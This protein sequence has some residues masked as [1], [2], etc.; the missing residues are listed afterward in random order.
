MVSRLPQPAPVLAGY[1]AVRPLGSGGFADVYLYE[2]GMPRREVA[3]KV[4]LAELCSVDVREMF[5]SE[6]TLMA[7]LST[8]PSALTVYEANISADGRPYLVMEYCPG[9]F[10][11]RFRTER[12][13]LH[14]V[15]QAAI[16]VG[17]VL[18]TT[19]RD[20]VLHRDVKPANILITSYGRP[21]LADFGVAATLARAEGGGVFGMSIPWSAP[22]VIVGETSGTVESEVW[23]FCATVYSLLAGRSPFEL[24]GRDNSRDD[25]QRR[26]LGRRAAPSLGRAD[27]P[28]ELERLL[29]AGLSKDPAGRPR[30]VLDV[31]RGIQLAE[32]E[33]GLRPSALDIPD[34]KVVDGPPLLLERRAAD[35]ISGSRGS[36]ALVGTHG[37]TVGSGTTTR[38]GR[39]IRTVPRESTMTVGA[40]VAAAPTGRRAARPPQ[41]RRGTTW[42][43]AGLAAALAVVLAAVAALLLMPREDG[44]IPQVGTVRTEQGDDTVTFR[45]DDPGLSVG[46]SFLVRVEGGSAGTDAVTQEA[47]DYTV[48]T[49]SGRVCVTV[50]VVRGT[51]SGQ[52]SGAVCAG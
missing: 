16:A 44:S 9:S 5:L 41:R 38:S 43:V 13:P 40:S 37:A 10:G 50:T 31:L 51:L 17:S 32:A 24:P 39:R 45:W 48:S 7:R 8:H 30:S 34:A 18:E 49:V 33:L 19:H 11:Q 23:A 28:S 36:I 35:D 20:G 2:Q 46:D 6:A 3:V 52:P 14:E 21:V 47:T 42:L 22:E 29:L 12:L 4:L 27:V 25:V 1:T 26:I 15:L